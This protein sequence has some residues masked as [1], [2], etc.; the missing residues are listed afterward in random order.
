MVV[1]IFLY[2][3]VFLGLRTLVFS[4]ISRKSLLEIYQLL[5]KDNRKSGVRFFC[6]FLLFLLYL[7]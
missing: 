3:I 2:G 1:S 5:V 4:F 6:F 7:E